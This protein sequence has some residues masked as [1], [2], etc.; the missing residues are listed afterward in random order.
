[1]PKKKENR[2]PTPEQK[3]ARRK[4]KLNKKRKQELAKLLRKKSRQRG[5]NPYSA[6]RFHQGYVFDPV[7]YT[8]LTASLMAPERV[9]MVT[10]KL[11]T[12]VSGPEAMTLPEIPG[13]SCEKLDH[14]GRVCLVSYCG[15][16]VAL[17]FKRQLHE[18]VPEPGEKVPEGVLQDPIEAWQR[19]DLLGRSAEKANYVLTQTHRRLEEANQL[20]TARVQTLDDLN[21]A[22]TRRI[23]GLLLAAKVLESE[24]QA[25]QRELKLA[26][27]KPIPAIKKPCVTRGKAR[28]GQSNRQSNVKKQRK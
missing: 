15:T 20:L 5:P 23:E 27:S 14:F 12:V 8:V 11:K 16:E 1:M 28:A 4:R 25:L 24:K 18:I 22:A 21:D 7:R 9:E 17:F 13:W 3:A 26:T 2:K 10:S 19:L 6:V